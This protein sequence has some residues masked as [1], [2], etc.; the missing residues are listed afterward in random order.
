M[1]EVMVLEL[2]ENVKGLNNTVAEMGFKYFIKK[3]VDDEL[4]L[5]ILNN[6]IKALLLDRKEK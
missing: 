4:E 2:L 3:S 5:K 6:T 1:N